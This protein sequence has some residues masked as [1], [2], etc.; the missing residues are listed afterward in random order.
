MYDS[1]PSDWKVT[2]LR[3]V[4][5]I[6]AGDPAP[7]GKHYFEEGTYP[8]VRTQDVGR[9][10]RSRNFCDTKDKVNDM[11]VRENRLR[12][13]PEGT[14]LIPK[15]GASTLLNNRVRLSKPA[16][17][18][19]HLATVVPH[20][21]VSGLFLYYKLCQLDA[22]RLLRNPGYPSLSLSDLKSV[23]V[24]VPSPDNQISI[25]RT[26][27]RVDQ[28]IERTEDVIAQT[29]QLRDALL[30]KLL[31]RGIPGHHTEWKE[32]SGIGTVPTIWQ[33]VLIG[34]IAEIITGTTPSRANSEYYGGP[35]PWV[36]PSD[37]KGYYVRKSDESL[38]SKGAFFA[39]YVPKDSVL[40]SC[41]G[42]IGKI[43]IAKRPLFFNQQIN[44]C[45]PNDRVLPS[46]LYWSLFYKA[47][48]MQSIAS[49]TAVPILNKR[50]FSKIRIGLPTLTE[51]TQISK[52]LSSIID[53]IEKMEICLTGAKR[54]RDSLLQE[55]L[56]GH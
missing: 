29:G 51:Q 10:K 52:V 15:S 24:S 6:G 5:K 7:Q 2:R 40:V 3:D 23:R 31:T 47:A 49:Q 39:K 17:V 56:T 4:A 9:A 8:F 22:R 48:Y 16:Y 41:I 45:K 11:A 55:L 19:S 13:W 34:D 28:S 42:T 26:L 38:T 37:L 14:I 1:L 20:D 35:F 46:F 32:I 53:Y 21:K 33:D 12:L 43:A 25:A 44:A 50:E 30:H 54:L 18:S 27:N 36:K